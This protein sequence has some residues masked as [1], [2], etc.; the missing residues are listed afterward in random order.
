MAYQMNNAGLARRLGKG[1]RNRIREAFE[2]INNGDQD[3]GDPAFFSS[4]SNSLEMVIALALSGSRD[5]AAVTQKIGHSQ[6][7]RAAAHLR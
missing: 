5:Q 6:A 7:N 4:S 2:A 1:R 3:V